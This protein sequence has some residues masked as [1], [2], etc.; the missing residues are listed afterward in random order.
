MD[1]WGR[2]QKIKQLIIRTR[3]SKSKLF[4]FNSADQW[5]INELTLYA[6]NPTLGSY[7][8]PYDLLDKLEINNIHSP[9]EDDLHHLNNLNTPLL[10][11]Q[12]YLEN[13]NISTDKTYIYISDGES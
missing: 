4:I 2:L 5:A 8:I 9:T 3:I 11:N 12:Y 1:K 10:S 7:K 6:S 13:M